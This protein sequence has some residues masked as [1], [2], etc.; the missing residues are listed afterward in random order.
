MEKKD[1]LKVEEVK[2][3]ALSDEVKES[4]SQTVKKKKPYVKPVIQK[5]GFV[6]DQYI[7]ACGNL[8]CALPGN[9]PQTEDGS[10]PYYVEYWTNRNTGV[11]DETSHGQYDHNYDE[12]WNM[13]PLH[14]SCANGSTTWR[15]GGTATEISNPNA[16]IN[17][18]NIGNYIDTD[19]QGRKMYNATWVTDGYSHVGFIHIDANRPNHS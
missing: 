3:A 9:N 10:T 6:P 4:T 7:A 16:T 13:G 2:T 19:S 15:D 18:V 17:G 12:G 1:A 11:V 8:Y 14:G 5:E